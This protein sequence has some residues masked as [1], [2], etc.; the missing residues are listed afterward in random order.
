MPQVAISLAPCA[1]ARQRLPPFATRRDVSFFI[2]AFHSMLK[3]RFYLRRLDFTRCFHFCCC[4]VSTRYAD[5]W[6]YSATPDRIS[7]IQASSTLAHACL[8][9]STASGHRCYRAAALDGIHFLRYAGLRWLYI[10]SRFRTVLI[11]LKMQIHSRYLNAALFYHTRAGDRPMNYRLFL[12]TGLSSKIS[13]HTCARLR[14]IQFDGL[15]W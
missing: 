9:L 7:A 14:L 8:P 11:P 2:A 15:R 3:Q 1:F 4:C 13:R 6:Y 12:A 5:A 10:C